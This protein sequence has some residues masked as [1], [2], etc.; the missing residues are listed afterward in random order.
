MEQ[1]ELL[2]GQSAPRTSLPGPATTEVYRSFFIAGIVC[3]LTAGCTLGAIAMLGIALKGSYIADVWTPYVLAHANSQLYGW[4]GFFV[5]G[6]GLQQHAPR[7]DR[8]RAFH[9]LARWSLVLM[10]IG[11]ALRFAAEPLVKSEPAVWMPAGVLSCILQFVAV[12]LFVTNTQVTRHRTGAPLGWEGRF[13]LASL[14]WML[15]VAAAEPFFFALAHQPDPTKGIMFVAE[16]FGP[17]RDAQ[18]LGFVALMIF[19]VSLTKM[20][21]LFGARPAYKDL[22][23]TSLVVWNLGLIGRM[24]GWVSY[25]QNGM[26]ADA[27][28]LYRTGGML[29]AAAGLLFVLALRIFEPVTEVQ[30][31]TKFV[32]AAF[33]WLLAVGALLILEP[34]HLRLTGQPFS[35]PYT[36]GIR[37]ALTVGFI[38]QMILGVGMRFVHRFHGLPEKAH[39]LVWAAFLLVN[40]G[41]AVRVALEIATDYSSAA[42][43]PMGVTGFIELTGLGLWAWVVAKPLLSRRRDDRQSALVYQETV[44]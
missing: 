18:F 31:S 38:S 10:A 14:G 16:Y 25:F 44:A 22:A 33:A 35:H 30:A 1:R 6:F 32:R 26:I 28:R 9:V 36:G 39:G 23:I 5:I 29:L 27:D 40:L 20:R 37:H 3:V 24:I 43:L 41:N 34:L 21:E 19:G 17:Y 42:F 12:V 15:V 13:V 7:I 11:I 2:R 8:L 4:V